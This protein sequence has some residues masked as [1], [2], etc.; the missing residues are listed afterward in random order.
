MAPFY[1]TEGEGTSLSSAAGGARTRDGAREELRGD[2]AEEPERHHPRDVDDRHAAAE[3]RRRRAGRH[4]A[5]AEIDLA[6]ERRGD[7]QLLVSVDA[8]AIGTREHRH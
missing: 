5:G 2:E 4:G 8:H 7:A 3:R 1:T 6:R